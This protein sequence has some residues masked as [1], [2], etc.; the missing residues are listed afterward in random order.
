MAAEV[1]SVSSCH[2]CTAVSQC[3]AEPI[4]ACPRSEPPLAKAEPS[5][6]DGNISGITGVRRKIKCHWADGA[7]EDWGENMREKQLCRHQ[8]QCKKGGQELLRVL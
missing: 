2:K 3:P 5:R 6:N 1:A 8:A 4:P 7:R